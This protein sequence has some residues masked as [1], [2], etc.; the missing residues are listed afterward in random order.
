MPPLVVGDYAK[1][2][3]QVIREPLPRS[4]RASHA[5]DREHDRAFVAPT[6][7]GRD[8]TVAES[9]DAFAMRHPVTIPLPASSPCISGAN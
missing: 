9:N 3:T 6:L 2:R 8:C 4:P 7:D 5:M 1:T